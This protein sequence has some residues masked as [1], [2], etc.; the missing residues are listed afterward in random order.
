MK[1]LGW[2]R[3]RTAHLRRFLG[4]RRLFRALERNERAA[5]ELDRAVREVLQE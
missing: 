4:G 2:I 5:A 3:G 1:L